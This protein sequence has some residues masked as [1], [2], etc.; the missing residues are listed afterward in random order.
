MTKSLRLVVLVSGR[1]SNLQALID[2]TA[3]SKIRSRVVAVISNKPDAMALER[4]RKAGVAHSVVV[5]KAKS[6]DIFFRELELEVNKHQPDL[7]VLAGFM[8]ILPPALVKAYKGRII[9]IHPSLLPA[10]PGLY[11]YKQAI[12]AGVKVTGCTVH[13]V[14]EGC[15]T[16]PIIIQ[17]VININN[18]DSEDSLS[19]RL[20]AHEHAALVESIKLIEDDK[21]V[22][23]GKKTLLR[24]EP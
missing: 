11:A 19:E 10:F 1:G 12:D 17:K 18:D 4:A 5:S 8:K 22:L 2:A 7:I 24:G 23:Q 9:N 20:L 6:N 13:F 15:D 21:L 14:D 16:G 3:Q